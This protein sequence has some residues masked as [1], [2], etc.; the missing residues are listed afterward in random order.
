M[1]GREGESASARHLA[2][3]GL[4]ILI[5]INVTIMALCSYV[6]VCFSYLIKADE[7]RKVRQNIR[8]CSTISKSRSEANF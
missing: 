7:L 2:A 6:N 5:I 3:S 4:V 1:G 8:R